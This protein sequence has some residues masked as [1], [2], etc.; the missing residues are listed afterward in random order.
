MQ[1]FCLTTLHPIYAELFDHQDPHVRKEIWSVGDT[2]RRVF[3]S[4][5][6]QRGQKIDEQVQKQVEKILAEELRTINLSNDIHWLKLVVA[7]DNG[8]LHSLVVTVD[9][10]PSDKL[11]QQVSSYHWP[12]TNGFFMAKL[13]FVVGS[14]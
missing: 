8:S 9:G 7:G 14:V 4:E 10:A 13:F 12:A 2:K 5:W 6:G 11:T 1:N 3:L